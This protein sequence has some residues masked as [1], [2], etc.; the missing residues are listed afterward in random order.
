[1]SADAYGHEEADVEEYEE[2]MV[3]EEVEEEEEDAEDAEESG[4]RQ[5]GTMG[6][7]I[8]QENDNGTKTYTM[9]EDQPKFRR[10]DD[11]VTYIGEQVKESDADSLHLAVVHVKREFKVKKKVQTTV[12]FDEL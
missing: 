12:E 10:I 2:E 5:I 6:M 1:M 9:P 7:A 8:V 3:E 11:V 4:R